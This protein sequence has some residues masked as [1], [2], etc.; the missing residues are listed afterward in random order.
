MA[1][2]LTGRSPVETTGRGTGVNDVTLAHKVSVVER[3][4]ARSG[5]GD[6]PLAVLGA[7][8]AAHGP[9]RPSAS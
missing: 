2:A 8:K 3:A 1:A 6:G 4:L 5:R 9:R 7:P